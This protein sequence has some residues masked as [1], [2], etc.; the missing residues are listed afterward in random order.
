MMV[1]LRFHFQKTCPHSA[2]FPFLSWWAV[3]LWCATNEGGGEVS[4]WL[5]SYSLW[6]TLYQATWLYSAWSAQTLPSF[7]KSTGFWSLQGYSCTYAPMLCVLFWIL[8]H[9]PDVLFFCYH[10]TCMCNACMMIV[11]GPLLLLYTSALIDV[12]NTGACI[13]LISIWIVYNW[14]KLPHILTLWPWRVPSSTTL[15][16]CDCIQHLSFNINASA[17][18]H[19]ITLH[20]LPCLHSTIL[21]TAVPHV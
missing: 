4:S 18:S 17:I 13:S 15:T 11:T 20:T 19:P 8:R 21:H 1:V 12:S 9:C 6:Q 2:S 5:W 16:P 14:V 3:N 7:N 10:V